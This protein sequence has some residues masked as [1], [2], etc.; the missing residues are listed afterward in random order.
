MAAIAASE[1]R[2]PPLLPERSIACSMLSQVSTPNPTASLASS[3]MA[4]MPRVT[5]WTMTSK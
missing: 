4:A 2:L 1:P 3:A 5:W